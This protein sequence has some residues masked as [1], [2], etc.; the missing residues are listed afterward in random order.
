MQ[1]LVLGGGLVGSAIVTDLASTFPVTCADRSTETLQALEKRG[2]VKTIPLDFSDTRALKKLASGFDL[3]V[4][5]VPGFLGFEVLKALIEEK[6]NVV[7]ISFFPEDALQLHDLAL[8]NN[9]TV[10][11]DC[12]VA[13][14]MSNMIAG[15]HNARM[16]LT[17][18]E[19]LV[20]GLPVVRQLPYQYKA[21]FSPV[22]VLEEYIRPARF[23]KDGKMVVKEAL[24]DVE[25]IFFPGIGTLEAFNTDGLRSLAITMPHVP[26]M[27][28][29]TL[30]Y[31]GHA[32]LMKTLRDSG[33][34][35]KEKIKVGSAEI[36]PIDVLAKIIF[37]Q[38]KLQ[39]GEEDFTIMRVVVEGEDKNEKTRFTYLLRDRYDTKNRITSMARTTAYTCTAA[40][41]LVA[42]GL[43]SRR[44]ISPPEFPGADEKAFAF[45]LDYLRKRNVQYQVSRER[46]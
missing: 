32:A 10:I 26:D 21:V 38:W 37:P 40:V 3:V 34:L 35:S 23:V 24:S 43:F 44:G 19:C 46:I 22:D 14:G 13:P 8:K 41:H 31:P 42:E 27:I 7:D 4:G 6:K 12:G 30:R 17:R 29:R 36:A 33:F 20:G 11:T 2:P 45:V 25:E 16:K 39:P 15:F 28:E 18:F 5:A 9:V 1:I